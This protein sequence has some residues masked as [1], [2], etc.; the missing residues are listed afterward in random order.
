MKDVVETTG[1]GSAFSDGIIT[2]DEMNAMTNSPAIE[3]KSREVETLKNKYDEYKNE[4]EDIENQVDKE[5]E[6]T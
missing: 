5:L 3:A 1:I 2:A 6:W 4:L